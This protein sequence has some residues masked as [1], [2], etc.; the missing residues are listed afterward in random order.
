MSPVPV[1]GLRARLIKMAIQGVVEDGLRDLGWFDPTIHDDP[2]GTRRHRPVTFYTKPNKWDEPITLNAV[3]VAGQDVDG[4]DG[5][6]G[7][8]LSDDRWFFYVD[9]YAESDSVAEHIVHDARDI[10]RGKMPSIGRTGAYVDVFDPREATPPFLFRL[11]VVELAVDRARL[12]E[13]PW[14]A[15]W[16]SLSFEV[17]DDYYD[18]DL[19]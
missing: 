16:Y 15:H 9:V 3:I 18:E 17:E 8:N 10:L 6:I 4:T 11:P 7:S 13:H 12:S 2:P 19:A 14:Q 5:E 1:G